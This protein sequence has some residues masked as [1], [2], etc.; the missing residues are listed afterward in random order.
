M[1]IVLAND[2]C[3]IGGVETWMVSLA[4]VLK[5]MGHECELFFFRHGAMERYIPEDCK[6]HFGNLGDLLKLVEARRFD[7]VH[8]NSTDWHSGIAAV[9]KTGAHLIL[10][11]HGRTISAWT[12]ENC[13]GFASC[14]R[15]QVGEQE[16][17]GDISVEVIHNGVNTERFKPKE[18]L[19]RTAPPIVAWVGRGN[20]AKQK[21]IDKLA[22]VAPFIK[23][24]GFR[25]WLI[26]PHGLEAV[27]EVLPGVGHALAPHADFWSGVPME[28][29]PDLYREISASGGLILSTSSF[30][31]LP[32]SLLE[33]QACGCPV[34]GPDVQG[35]NECVDPEHGGILYP[36]DTEPAELA[37]LITET[38]RDTERMGLMRAACARR[39]RDYFSLERMAHD[40]LRLYQQ[41]LGKDRRPLAAIRSWLRRARRLSWEQYVEQ[42]WTAGD[43]QYELSRKLASR[44]DW[45]LAAVIA[46]SALFTCP[47]LFVR[48]PRAFHLLRT[49]LR[50]KFPS[51]S[52]PEPE[53]NSQGTIRSQP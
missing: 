21:R 39:M 22:E 41:A 18:D 42:N 25:L 24:A 52:K 27:E 33:A 2:E 12:S 46:R 32:M 38:L 3:T 28:R 35:V 5:A 31:G 6:A 13:D 51:K 40:Y 11:S 34:I 15:W 47:T 30:E 29:M 14:C 44:G 23:A 9:R 37:R 4:P 16:E 17:F 1:K 50:A 7:I 19:P 48:P 10:T 53:T 26:E 36:F 49:E 8:A 45:K 20:D 43:R